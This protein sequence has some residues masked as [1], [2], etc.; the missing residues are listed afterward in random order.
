MGEKISIITISYNSET[1]IE[2]TFKSVLAQTYRPLE[3]VLVDGASKDGTIPLIEKYLPIFENA[4]I[5]VSFK[6]EP[7]KG[8]S[9][10]FNKGIERATGEIIGIT[11]TDDT[12]LPNMLDFVSDNFPTSVDVFYGNILWDDKEN[13]IQYVR[14]SSADLSDLKF[15]LKALHP[16]VYIRRSAYEKYGVYD[17]SY[18]YCMD[19]ELLARIQRMGGK[20][21][22]TDT[23]LVSVAAG[24]VSD[25]NI[26]GVILEGKK[27]AIANGVPF[28]EA[29]VYFRKS[30]VKLL[31]QRCIKLIPGVRKMVSKKK[32]EGDAKIVID[33]FAK[34]PYLYD[35]YRWTGK[36][37]F[38]TFIKWRFVSKYK[39]VYFKRRCEQY[40]EKNK[41]LFLFY[42]FFYE[43][44]INKYG[45]D[46][47]AKA[48]IGPGFIVRHVGSIAINSNVSIGKDVE[49]LQGVTI[50]YER[51]GKRKG[52]PTIGNRV[53]IG[54]NAVIVGNITV[55]NNVLI[56]PGAFV[57]FNVPDY[58]IVI[59]NPGRIIHKDTAIDAYIINTLDV[60]PKGEEL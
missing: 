7:D 13:H 19:K 2:K 4:G 34:K 28:K 12:I 42:R 15:K 55:G 17:T 5:E 53:W 33:N 21:L 11:N 6:S 24:G 35:L 52:N 57:N 41:I 46:I 56:A 8:I 48:Y 26:K 32:G 31:F 23:T 39:I 20:F 43:R 16:A 38:K 14:K 36:V 47:G 3:Y 37:N 58:S 51:R 50:G 49:I 40:R 44:C 54:A 27:I 59:G 9:D 25:K 29:E 22:Y 60:M 10:A 18:R 45:V 30:Y 1:T